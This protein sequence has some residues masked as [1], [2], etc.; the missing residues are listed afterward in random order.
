VICVL[1]VASGASWESAALRLLGEQP[2]VVVLKRC[3]DVDD[4]LAAATAGQAQVAVVALDA[5]GLDA[6]AVEH[7]RR[8]QVRPVAVVTGGTAEVDQGR[9]RAH[10][11]GIASLL[12]DGLAGLG[13]AVV[14]SDTDEPPAGTADAVTAVPVLEGGGTGRVIVVWGPHGAPGRTTVAT[15]LAGLLARRGV[16]TVHVDAD[17]Y[18]G[19]VAQQLG[20][21]DEVS[22]LLSAA[23]L[24]AGGLLE[25]R[26]ATVPRAL[27]P[28]LS[29][30]T[31]LPRPDRWIEIRAGAVEH[32]LEALREH[33][34]VV[35][36]TGFCLEEDPAS[37]FGSRPGR[38]SMTLGALATADEG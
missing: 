13:E 32:L 8:H 20:I 4:L 36:D 31:G 23:R 15:A 1:I 10:R 21:L 16:P 5:P 27:G 14:T 28:Q 38:N 2:G 6:S 22:G 34:H 30:I 7:L 26:L 18:G 35:V 9:L 24:A 11:I 29:V 12:T 37:E 33:A 19:A 3:V 17:P 25:E